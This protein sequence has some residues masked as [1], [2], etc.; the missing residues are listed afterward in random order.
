MAPLPILDEESNAGAHAHAVGDRRL[1]DLL[2]WH[3]ARPVRDF[4]LS[5]MKR[6]AQRLP[7]S[8]LF[9]GVLLFIAAEIAS[10]VV[11]AEHI[12]FLWALAVLVVVSA[13][14][15]L[16]SGASASECWP[17]PRRGWRGE[18]CPVAICLTGSSSLSAG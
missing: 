7:C 3:P 4:T 14:G 8:V 18:R 9:L 17:T 12:G 6:P 16:L 1:L 2:D 11:V 10:F 5:P 13:L 15:P